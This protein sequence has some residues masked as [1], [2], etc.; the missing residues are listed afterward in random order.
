MNSFLYVDLF[1][2]QCVPLL[3]SFPVKC[4]IHLPRLSFRFTF[5]SLIVEANRGKSGEN[6]IK[7]SQTDSPIV[8][9][10]DC[11][12]LRFAQLRINRVVFLIP[13]LVFL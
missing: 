12:W 2:S 10:G 4:K 11:L 8:M 6:S 1:I 13:S 7:E 9:R 5:V 3:S